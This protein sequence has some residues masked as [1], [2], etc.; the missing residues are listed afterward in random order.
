VIEEPAAS[1]KSELTA[2]AELGKKARQD[3]GM[4]TGSGIRPV[5]LVTGAGRR[6]GIATAAA[7]RLA[8]TGWD[9][10]FTHFEPYDARM[11]WGADTGAAEA[12]A[13]RLKSVGA[14]SCPIEADFEVTEAPRQIFEQVIGELGPVGA[15]VLGHCESVDSGIMDTTVESFDRHFAVN[16]RAGW[17]LIREY[18]S[19]FAGDPGSGRIVALTSDATVGNVPY[20]A[21]KG[22]LDRIV[23]A[24]AKELSGLGIT[25]NCV[26]PGPTNNG[27]MTEQQKTELTTSIPLGRLGEP[28]D[29]ANLIAFLCSQ[30]GG[31]INGQLIQSDGGL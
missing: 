13:D 2:P 28:R 12:L 16:T 9:V 19:Q 26:D 22:A 17:L 4:T 7:Q 1:V 14:R 31:W 8:E 23:I 20:G 29:A 3:G 18:A 10:A 27:W 25:A 21:S 5:A 15:L 30:D 11:P 24:A 6:L